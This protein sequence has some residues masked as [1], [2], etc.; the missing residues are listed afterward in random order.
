MSDMMRP[1]AGGPAPGGMQEKMSLLNPTDMAAKAATGD[2]GR[3]QTVADFLQKN[4]GVRPE[5]PVEKLFAATKQQMQNRTM[6]GKL[7]VQ[8]G[9]GAIPRPNPAPPTRP[10]AAP[11][12]GMGG[13]PPAGGLDSLVS[14][15]R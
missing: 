12:P 6:A 7:G 2:V 4:F 5:D 13:P 11:G 1:P 3:G 9:Q 10:P 14:K 8:Q 15:I